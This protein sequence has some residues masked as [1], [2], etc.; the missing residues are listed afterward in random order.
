M[1]FRIVSPTNSDI[2]RNITEETVT[3]QEPTLDVA[4]ADFQRVRLVLPTVVEEEENSSSEQ[5]SQAQQQN[6]EP[7]QEPVKPV[8]QNA[9]P[10]RPAAS[11]EPTG[12]PTAESAP[13]CTKNN[14]DMDASSKK[15]NDASRASSRSGKSTFRSSSQSNYDWNGLG[16]ASSSAAYNYDDRY[17]TSSKFPRIRYP[18]SSD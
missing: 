5:V 8:E 9:Q 6:L 1:W 7:Q 17:K 16:T 2:D 10:L 14:P 13:G 18:I 15:I 11:L 4:P 12:A 3:V